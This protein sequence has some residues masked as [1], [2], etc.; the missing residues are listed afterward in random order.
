MRGLLRGGLAL[1]LAACREP[2]WAPPEPVPVSLLTPDVWSGSEAVLASAAFTRDRGLPVVLL[3]AD[4]LAVRRLDDT[5][6]A[7]QLPDLPGTQSLHVRAPDVLDFPIAIELRGFERTGEGPL[8]SGRLQVLPGW[9][10]TVVGNGV[11]GA[12]V[13]NL[14]STLATPLP[15][16]LH[17]PTCTVGVGPGYDP[18][19]VA[20]ATCEATSR[21]GRWRAWRVRPEVTLVED[22]LCSTG[23][24]FTAALA[25]GV[26][27]S[28]GRT[29]GTTTFLTVFVREGS[30]CTPVLEV[31]ALLAYDIVL[32]PRGDRAVVL[33][34]QYSSGSSFPDPPPPPLG[35]PVIEAATGQLAYRIESILVAPTAAFSGDGDTLFLAGQA[36]GDLF[37][38]SHLTVVRF[39]DGVALRS[40]PLP[41]EATAIAPD[42]SRPWLYVAGFTPAR[43]ARLL[44]LDRESLE[45]VVTLAAPDSVDGFAAF[46]WGSRMILSPAEQR[47]YVVSAN[48]PWHPVTRPFLTRFR[49]P[50]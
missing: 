12:V 41:L 44:V 1:L 21:S 23:D 5:T 34:D 22:S 37:G 46:G 39:G 15:D 48:N 10:P 27:A 45:V 2:A 40:R 20:L 9:P 16:S 28:A 31:V 19:T 24:R 4:T 7:A 6:V 18:W 32:S 43:Q 47:V 33:A 14:H 50:P 38:Q 3:N 13:W 8:L 36:W 17:D 30:T 35:V 49:T 26:S 42:A 11:A 25:P 29:G